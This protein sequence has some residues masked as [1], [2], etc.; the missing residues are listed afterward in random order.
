LALARWDRCTCV[1]NDGA[2]R[3][4]CKAVGV[5]VLWGLELLVL[6]VKAGGLTVQAAAALGRDMSTNNPRYVTPATLQRFLKR[7]GATR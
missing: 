7:I 2:V 4:E 1:T 6:T 3:R 5:P